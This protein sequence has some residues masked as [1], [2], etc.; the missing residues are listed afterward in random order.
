V[1]GPG[2]ISTS[3]DQGEEGT[4]GEEK[5]ESTS[6]SQKKKG[7]EIEEEEAKRGKKRDDRRKASAL[8]SLYLL[9]VR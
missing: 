8:L 4:L 2:L 3:Y 6:L 7:H 9:Q 5:G 1:E